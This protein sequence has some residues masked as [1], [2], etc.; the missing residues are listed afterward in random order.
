MTVTSI[1]LPDS[2]SGPKPLFLSNPALVVLRDLSVRPDAATGRF[3]IK[4]A[5]RA[6]DRKLGEALKRVVPGC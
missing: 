5:W 2:K 1:V 3:I 6:N 4:A